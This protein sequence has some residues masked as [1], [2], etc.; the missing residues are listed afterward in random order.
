MWGAAIGLEGTVGAWSEGVSNLLWRIFHPQ[1]GVA[2]QPSVSRVFP[3][4]GGAGT[5]KC[6]TRD[7]WKANNASSEILVLTVWRGL[8][9]NPA[10]NSQQ[11]RGSGEVLF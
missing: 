2:A 1:A 4:Q 11:L 7:H 10:Q 5:L 8:L 3:N 6:V 9:R